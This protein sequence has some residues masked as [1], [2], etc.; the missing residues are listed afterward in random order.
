[1]NPRLGPV[2][3]IESSCDDTSVAIIDKEGVICSLVSA[4]QDL[5]HAP[6]GGVVPEVAS[7]QHTEW[8]LPLVQVALERAA[9]KLEEIEGYAVTSR[10]GLLGSLMVGVVTAKTLALAMK[11]PLIGVNHIEGHLVAPLIRDR[12]TSDSHNFDCPYLALVISGGHTHLFLVESFGK[13]ILFGETLDDAAGEAFDKFGKLVG[14]GFPGGVA[15]DR[16]AQGG[17]VNAFEFPRSMIHD[18]SF[19]FSFSGL[20]S[21]AQRLL[22]GRSAEWLKEH[23]ADLCASFQEAIVDVLLT[24]LERAMDELG[25]KRMVLTGG[26]SANSRLRARAEQLAKKRNWQLAVPALKYCTDN[27]AMIALAGQLRLSRG[28]RDK[29]DLGP[30]AAAI[31]S[32]YFRR[33]REQI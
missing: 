13:Y 11:K 19:D 12:E 27:A 20:K 30:A 14:L 1:M 28:E 24:K 8:V 5:K 31:E 33:N 17:Q 10:P 4:N 6:F 2:L 15:V 32:D 25:L 18:A 23:Q 3:A 21:A 26:V 22:E 9:L 16:M 7:R 29:M